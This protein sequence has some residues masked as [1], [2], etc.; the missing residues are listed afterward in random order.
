[1]VAFG[2]QPGQLLLRRPAS[3]PACAGRRPSTGR[4]VS[5]RAVR[6]ASMAVLPPPIDQHLGAQRRASRPAPPSPAGPARSRRPSPSTPSISSRGILLEAAG[7]VDGVKALLQQLLRRR[8][9]RMVQLRSRTPSAGDALDVRRHHRRRQP[10]GRGQ[11]SMPPAMLLGLKDRRPARRSAP[12]SR[13]PPAPTG[14][15][16][17]MATLLTLDSGACALA[18]HAPGRGPARRRSA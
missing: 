2:E 15:L 3:R 14:P 6:A 10:E 17:M 16:P 7:H 4:P 1:M 9:D 5:R 8:R 18:D 11:A 12:G 13:P